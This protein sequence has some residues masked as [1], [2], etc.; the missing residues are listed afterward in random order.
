MK[1]KFE[2]NEPEED[3]YKDEEYER[4]FYELVLEASLNALGVIK[5]SNLIS[6]E[7]KALLEN[8]CMEF[9]GLVNEYFKENKKVSGS[10]QY[11]LAKKPENKWLD[12]IKLLASKNVSQKE[13]LKDVYQE[14]INKIE[15]RRKKQDIQ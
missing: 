5:S 7:D 11:V 2:N 15:K 10:Y 3:K 12:V 6:E 13:I 9:L 4:A 1:E 8:D 14:I